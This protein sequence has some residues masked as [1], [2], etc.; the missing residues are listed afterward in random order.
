MIEKK[1]VGVE[2]IRVGIGASDLSTLCDKGK[3]SLAHEFEEYV[4]LKCVKELEF[5][6]KEFGENAKIII[7]YLIGLC[8][9]NKLTEGKINT[10]PYGDLNITAKVSEKGLIVA[11]SK[12][13][14]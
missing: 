2:E 5:L 14:N 8:E 7:A 6:R 12:K 1:F 3:Y 10:I 11:W 4:P 9:D 13:I